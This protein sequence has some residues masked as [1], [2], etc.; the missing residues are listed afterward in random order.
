MQAKNNKLIIVLGMHRS[1]TSAIT[2]SLE[3]MGV[4][5]GSDMLPA[6]EANPTGFWENQECVDINNQL[7]KHFGSGYD[8]LGIEDDQLIDDEIICDLKSRAI[9]LLSRKLIENNGIWG[10]K[11]PRICRLLSFWS[12]VFG[13]VKCDV[14]FIVAV[15]NPASV[16]ASLE[17]RDRI[18][19]EKSYY[20]WLQH[21]LPTLSAFKKARRIFVDYDEF[22]SDPH[23]QIVRISS[24][25]ELPLLDS[26]S[27]LFKFFENDFLAKSLRHTRF[28]QD[29]LMRD[30]RVPMIVVETYS[31]LHGLAKDQK[32]LET[33]ECQALVDKL[34]FFFDSISPLFGYI[35]ALEKNILA[36][37]EQ[38]CQQDGIIAEQAGEIARQAA[39]IDEQAM[40]LD[41]QGKRFTEIFTSPSWR[42]TRPLRGIARFVRELR[43][44][45]KF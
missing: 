11:D 36:L 2:K 26:H 22:L 45:L 20:L 16:V 5:L 32:M 8:Y 41:M 4:N 42:L 39:F 28:T 38:I 40:I 23:A 10:F 7:L 25:L 12:D 1:G 19:A 17:K 6:G 15:R 18:P 27:N 9:Q 44:R 35:N 31:L 29:D 34:T 33:S 3:L 13:E 30:S 24:K 37:S 21:V 43:M 14:D